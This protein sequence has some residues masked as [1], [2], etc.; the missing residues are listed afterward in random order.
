M[1]SRGARTGPMGPIGPISPA[2]SLLLSLRD[3]AEVL[4]LLFARSG[5]GTQATVE[6]LVR[7]GL[8]ELAS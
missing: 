6:A 8:K 3:L 4:E 2:V 5:A 1:I 7:A